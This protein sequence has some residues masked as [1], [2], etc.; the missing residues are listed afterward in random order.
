ME[1]LKLYVAPDGNDGWSGSLP[2]PASDGRDG[3]LASIGRARDLARQARA[4]SSATIPVTIVLRGGTYRLI[5]P[6]QF[7]RRDSGTHDAP[8]RIVAFEGEQP[9]LSGARP[10][11]DWRPHQD[12]IWMAAVPWL[13]D[14]KKPV[15]QLFVGQERMQR[16]R[17]PK[18]DPADPLYGGWALTEAAAD[19]GSKT[20]FVYR[21]GTFRRPW[22]RPTSGEVSF[23]DANNGWMSTVAIKA[24]DHAAR[25]VELV[26][27]GY[28]WDPGGD[29]YAFG[30]RIR[31]RVENILEELDQP[32]EWCYDGDAGTLYFKPPN[33]EEDLASVAIP[34]ASGLIRVVNASHFEI[35][36]L[37]FTQTTAGDR[38]HPDGMTGLGVMELRFSSDEIEYVGDALCLDTAVSCLVE[39][40]R[41]V[42]V[43]GNAVYLAYRC[44]RNTVRENEISGAGANGI[45]LAGLGTNVWNM[46]RYPAYNEV[47]NNYIHDCGVLNKGIAGISLGDS[48]GNT[49]AHNLIVRMPHH[50]IG[51]GNNPRGK[52][53]VEYNEL[54]WCA[55]E[56]YDSGG[57]NSWM[58]D[59]HREIPRP[60]HIIRNNLIADQPGTELVDGQ[61]RIASVAGA[62]GA[63][64]SPAIYLDNWT[65]GCLVQ[66]N[67][68]LRCQMGVKIHGGR[69][70]V[71]ENNYFLESRG[72]ITLEDWVTFFREDLMVMIG[73]MKGNRI[74]RNV[75]YQTGTEGIVLSLYGFQPDVLAHSDRNIFWRPSSTDPVID[76]RPPLESEPM[77]EVVERLR[78]V[79]RVASLDDWQALGFD[80]A[81][82]IA[83]PGFR[84]I[85]AEDLD[86]GPESPIRALGIVPIDLR[87]V[88]LEPP[89]RQRLLVD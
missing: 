82:L 31:F 59:V 52:N 87:T 20:A 56:N 18:W 46:D 11:T 76:H 10:V 35:S 14:S 33:G 9:V 68:F 81:S 74:E 1:P 7:D 43:G 29:Y 88:G 25:T 39:R 45:V 75:F 55:R 32:G 2:D 80:V 71:I 89:A 22:A 49:I 30:P 78:D 77:L 41:F 50:G 67:V 51:L 73:F 17:W 79:P 54:R 44:R 8:T 38:M 34:V 24:V 40:C 64:P 48:D 53:V 15:R 83:D 42:D 13:R 3:P 37:T 62:A 58:E 72:A 26:R 84:D 19:P 70:N 47:S 12:G 36:G 57:I 66:N 85:D 5:E 86:V 28:D 27:S 65:S 63:P 4:G 21:D 16:A 61:L 6:V 23:Y 60:G 69:W